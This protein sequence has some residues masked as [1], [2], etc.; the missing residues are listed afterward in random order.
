MRPWKRSAEDRAGNGIDQAYLGAEDGLGR[1]AV[2]GKL[3][4]KGSEAIGSAGRS[5][6]FRIHAALP[7]FNDRIISGIVA[8]QSAFRLG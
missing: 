8:L 7:H 2:I 5:R 1:Q 4:R 6:I 3:H